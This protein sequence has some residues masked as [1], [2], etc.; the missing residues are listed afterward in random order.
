[1][2]LL[3]DTHAFLWWLEDNPKLRA[4][5]RELVS[6]PRAVVYVSTA[7]LWE[8]AIKSRLG[9]LD[10]GSADLLEEIA[11]NYFIQLPISGRHALLAGSLP[12][13]HEDPFDRMLIAQAWM[14]ELTIVT[15]DSAF[16]AYGVPT[17]PA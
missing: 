7:S 9:K 8:I 14:E 16:A 3:L 6:D 5:A 1:L 13:H 17:L 11:A 15:R 4:P 12:G 2:K 10:A